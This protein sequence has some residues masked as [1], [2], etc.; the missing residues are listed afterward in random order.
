M[1]PDQAHHSAQFQRF[2]LLFPGNPDGF[3]KAGLGLCSRG[4]FRFTESRR[5]SHGAGN[6][7]AGGLHAEQFALEPTK[8]SLVVPL[9]I[10][11]GHRHRFIKYLQGLLNLIC[12]TQGFGEHRQE[13]RTY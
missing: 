1:E 2:R 6:N 9:A 4:E 8:F 7:A 12:L 5:A 10:A 11:L 13:L 3:L